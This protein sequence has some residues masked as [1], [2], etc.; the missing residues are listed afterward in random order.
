MKDIEQVKKSIK[1][2]ASEL[3][4]KFGYDKTTLED[5]AR[6]ADKAKTLVYYHF[7]GKLD[8]LRE[9][10]EDEFRYIQANLQLVRSEVPGSII[11]SFM[12]YLEERMELLNDARVYRK[13]AI[14][15]MLSDN[16]DVNKTVRAIRGNFDEWEC[17]YFTRIGQTAREYGIF[18]D[19]VVP[20]TFGKM[21]M[22]LLKGIEVQF[23]L[24]EDWHASKAT[25]DEVLEKLL[26]GCV[27][28]TTAAPAQQPALQK[29]D[30]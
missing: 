17:A 22:L 23:F 1:D 13:F 27:A 5:I 30:A 3:F 4:E 25:F 14:D 12:A 16:G 15:A 8:L 21:V 7:G 10:V 9:A 29:A 6:K 26:R 19:A 11:N 28:S 20:E 24:S 2:S 18:S